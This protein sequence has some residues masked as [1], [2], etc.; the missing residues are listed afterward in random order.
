MLNFLGRDAVAVAGQ[1]TGL[2]TTAT[3]LATIIF[4]AVAGVCAGTVQPA[5]AQAYNFSKV[6]I[7]GNQRIEAATILTYLGFGKGETVSAAQLNDAYQRLQGSGLFEQV[8]LVPRGN[9]LV[10]QLRE[11]PTINRVS[12][13]GNRRLKDDVFAPLLK[14]RPR[15]VYSPSR[16]ELDAVTITKVYQSD[17]RLAATVDPVII[18]RSNNRVDV[19]FEVTEGRSVEVER[20]S[21]TGNRAFSD[22]RLRRVLETKQAGIL[23]Q[24]I[25]ADTYTP[26]RIEFDKQ[27]LQDFY[28]SRGYV[29]FQ[30]QAV[31]SEFTRERN[32]FFVTFQVREGQSFKFGDIITTSDLP[33][34]DPDEFAA[35]SKLRSGVTYNPALVENTI[36][37]MERLALQKGLNFIRVEPRLVRNDRALTLDLELVLT[38]GPRIIVER[39]DIEGNATTLDRVVRN[40][41]STVEGDPFN[42]RAIRESA[43]RIRALGFF[44]NADVQARE[45]SAPDQVV[46]DVNLEEKPT[47]SFNFGGAYSLEQGFGLNIAF[48]ERNFLGRGQSVS[49]S[50]VTGEDSAAFSFNFTEPN[51]LDRDLRFSLAA[52]YTESN[53]ASEGYNTRLIGLRPSLNFPVSDNGRMSVRVFG[54]GA[55][56]TYPEGYVP[57]TMSA[58]LEREVDR[59]TQVGAGVGFGYSFDNRR[60]GL[61]PQAGIRFSLDTDFGGLGA[62]YQYAKT[63]ASLTG[64]T[65]ILNDAVTLRGTIEGGAL[66]S[67][68]SAS[69]RATDRFFLPPSQMRGFAV[70]GVGP[71][72]LGTAA[73]TYPGDAVG[74]NFFAVARL[75]AEFPLGIPEE[76]GITGGVFVDVGSVWGLDDTAGTAAI[77]D[78]AKLRS[79]VGA[80]IFW[81][82]PIGP[83]R[84]NFTRALSK[85]DYDIENK[86]EFTISTTF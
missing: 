36:A 43:E 72:D 37:R 1:R 30:T 48:Q 39:I 32:A 79:V 14:S 13:E 76:Y 83:L 58:L 2:K 4:L 56:M 34:V 38:R 17:G 54:D 19:V 66:M 57:G 47:G 59:G 65:V 73:G 53:T 6:Q 78:S 11:Y 69:S 22:R 45:G 55:E 44:A 67:L 46:V 3:R 5:Q 61:N 75:E 16:A 60:T 74:G 31:S 23:R 25:R 29:D 10:V 8:N 26:D 21:F 85:E 68:N 80:S 20:L 35:V 77:D 70:N 9:L 15:Q 50:L 27:V 40:Q 71:R 82:T 12:V 42:P 33:D 7:E 84:F 18:R 49:L 62:D 28:L 64:R 81:N 51:F 86:F 63:E 41:F 52:Y 24:F